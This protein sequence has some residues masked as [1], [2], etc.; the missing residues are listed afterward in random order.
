MGNEFIIRILASLVDPSKRLKGSIFQKSIHNCI[1]EATYRL[2]FIIIFLKR[3]AR[4]Q[5]LNNQFIN[6]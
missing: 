4:V 6:V 2:Q 3:Q 5:Y 1:F